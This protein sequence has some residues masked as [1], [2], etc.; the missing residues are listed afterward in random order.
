M[1]HR[2]PNLSELIITANCQDPSKIF[3]LMDK[4]R[5]FKV[6]K[7]PD[8]FNLDSDDSFL[9]K[10]AEER[11]ENDKHDQIRTNDIKKEII[12]N[13]KRRYDPINRDLLC[14]STEF[15]Q[16]LEKVQIQTNEHNQVEDSTLIE[17]LDYD[18]LHYSID[19]EKSVYVD[20]ARVGKVGQFVKKIMKKVKDLWPSGQK[21]SKEPKIKYHNEH[22][23]HGNIGENRIYDDSQYKNIRQN[24]K[25]NENTNEFV[26]QAGSVSGPWKD[27]ISGVSTKSSQM[28]KLSTESPY[29]TSNSNNQ[30]MNRTEKYK[31]ASSNL[32]TSKKTVFF[33]VI[34]SLISLFNNVRLLN[35]KD[36]LQSEVTILR[37]DLQ[38]IMEKQNEHENQIPYD[39]AK[40]EKGTKIIEFPK[41]YTYGLLWRRSGANILSIFS[42]NF[43]VPF[44]MAG[45]T[46]SFTFRL[47]KDKTTISIGLLHPEH[48][49]KISAINKFTIGTD[50]NPIDEFSYDNPGNYEE[51]QISS[52]LKTD[53]IV[54]TVLSNHGNLRCTC[55]FKIYIFVIDDQ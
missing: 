28:D 55:I 27:H 25:E 2:Q 49:N 53:R 54:L 26:N 11:K 38:K 16:P 14:D 44:L 32:F 6:I 51:F 43:A 19:Y 47:P 39:I 46:G 34:V 45:Q 4:K 10:N 33:L 13:Q 31:N 24:E 7:D 3:Q 18:S 1:A 5:L 36:L 23:I 37:Q 41:Q 50:N 42:D 30:Q 15:D 20:G 35:T 40:I 48:S 17:D 52:P 8:S 29:R 22:F 21:Q 9:L 12:R